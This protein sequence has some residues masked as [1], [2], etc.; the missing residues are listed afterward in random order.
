MAAMSRGESERGSTA[1]ATQ[2]VED[3]DFGLRSDS[4]PGYET[5]VKRRRA[6]AAG[7]RQQREHETNQE[8]RQGDCGEVERKRRS[9]LR[10][11]PSGGYPHYP[12]DLD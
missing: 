1:G 3:W 4:T 11:G 8:P 9:R 10:L 2:R 6:P 5:Y 12:P 7:D